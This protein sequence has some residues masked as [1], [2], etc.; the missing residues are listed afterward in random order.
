MESNSFSYNSWADLPVG[1]SII[2]NID[3]LPVAVAR[4][5]TLLAACPE[6]FDVIVIVALLRSFTA[7]Q[8]PV[9]VAGGRPQRYA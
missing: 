2:A 4:L 8:N 7:E 9:L 1:I 6:A 5:P 3:D